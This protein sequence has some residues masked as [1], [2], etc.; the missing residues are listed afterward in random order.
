[1]VYIFCNTLHSSIAVERKL[2]KQMFLNLLYV[3]EAIYSDQ[4]LHLLP[5]IEDFHSRAH[6]VVH[7]SPRNHRRRSCG[8]LQIYNTIRLDIEEYTPQVTKH[9]I[10]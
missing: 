1:M 8:S 6:E 2:S 10:L 9:E 5:N 4:I 3:V 7:S